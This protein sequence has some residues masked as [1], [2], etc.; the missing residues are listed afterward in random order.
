MKNWIP[1]IF[2]LL[3]ALPLHAWHIVG[4]SMSY[5]FLGNDTYRIRLEIYRDCAQTVGAPFDNPASIGIFDENNFLVLELQVPYDDNTNDTI[6]LL[7]DNFVCEFPANIC[8]HRATYEVD[9]TLPPG[10]GKYTVTYQRCCRS[11]VIANLLAPETIGMTFTAEIDPDHPNS[12]PIFNQDIPLAIFAN[13]AFVYDGS[14]ADPD[15]D[16]LAYKLS[17]PLAGA[18]QTIPQPIPPPAPPYLPVTFAPNY[19]EDNMLG[20]NYPL[21]I[22]PATGEFTAVAPSLGAFQ[23]GYKVEE[24]RNGQLIGSTQREFL[25]VVTQPQ[26]TLNFDV[27]GRVL[28]DSLAPLDAGTVQLLK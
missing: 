14:A 8:I 11:L 27:S 12:S 28:I 1:A 25:F 21:K 17:T 26:P 2:L 9:V 19:A 10:T 4:G 22:D 24:Y 16:S 15:G 20:G 23:I 5:Q 18:D 6:S 3:T 7:P 13:I